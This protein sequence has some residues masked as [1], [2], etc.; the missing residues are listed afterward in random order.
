MALSSYG[1]ER[2]Q[3]FE[4]SPEMGPPKSTLKNFYCLIGH[5][6]LKRM[7]SAIGWAQKDLE[8]TEQPTGVL[9][10]GAT[11]EEAISNLAII[12]EIYGS[13]K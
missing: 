11:L 1:T 13:C 10:S 8:L 7:N 4:M 6:K 2:M 12:E 9:Q 5:F 3:I